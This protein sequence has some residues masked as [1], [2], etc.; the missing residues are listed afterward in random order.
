M[1]NAAFAVRDLLRRVGP[2]EIFARYVHDDL[3]GDVLSLDEYGQRPSAARG[4]NLLIYH[5]SIGEPEVL[6]F[7]FERRERLVLVYHNITPARYF[8]TL[9]PAFAELLAGGR[10]E[11]AALRERVDLALAVSAYN[12]AELEA[13]GYTD[14]RL[15]PLMV[16]TDRLRQLQPSPTTVAHLEKYLHGPLILFVGQLL[17]HKRPD[18]LLQAYHVLVTY[19]LPEAYLALVGPCTSDRYRWVLETYVRQLN[20]DRAWLP[21]RVPDGEL[22]A[23]FRAASVFMTLSEH[24]GVCVPLLEAMAFDLPVVARDFAA[25][26][27]T[28]GGA[29]LLL[30]AD[31]DPFLIAEALAR[32]LTDEVLRKELVTAGARRL[33]DFDPEAARATF[34]AHLADVA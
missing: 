5:A 16:E 3:T 12:A 11:L 29:G 28:L 21:G 10:V 30:P 34:L 19:L 15:S 17:P 7:L 25:I 23:F 26:P 6:K 14:V 13:L 20:L 32:L 8:A 31:D 9:D 4:Q 27:Q 22:A 24:E 2:S 33:A 18:L 1:T